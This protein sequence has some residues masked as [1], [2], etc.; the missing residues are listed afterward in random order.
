MEKDQKND[1]IAN[2][3]RKIAYLQM[4]LTLSDRMTYY[5]TFL[6]TLTIS[7]LVAGVFNQLN[8][9]D[10]LISIFMVIILTMVIMF[11]DAYYLQLC[12][13]Y[14]KLYN[15]V[16]KLNEHKISFNW[17]FERKYNFNTE[18][19]D[20]INIKPNYVSCFT[21]KSITSF[22]FPLL[23]VEI[24]LFLF[25]HFEKV[26][27]YISL[28]KNDS[29]LYT[30][31]AL[32]LL[33][34]FV[35]YCCIKRYNEVKE[36]LS[37]SKKKIFADD[38]NPKIKTNK[39]VVLLNKKIKDA[40]FKVTLKWDEI[41]QKKNIFN[42]LKT[43]KLNK[44]INIKYLYDHFVMKHIDCDLSV[45]LLNDKGKLLSDKLYESL[46][47]FDNRVYKNNSIYL[48]EDQ[49]MGEDSEENIF[50]Y[51]NDLP[52]NVS[53]I[54][55]AVNIYDANVK[56]QT[57]EMLSEASVI[58]TNEVNIEVCKINLKENEEINNYSGIIAAELTKY[59]TEWILNPLCK[60]IMASRLSSII[61][62]YE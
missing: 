33:L 3:K 53:K 16:R 20:F 52:K 39:N 7:I 30:V 12:K 46:I 21:S 19:Y 10:N 27:I 8:K 49:L 60:G 57:F 38:E 25:F 58:I 48:T 59:D 62:Y 32:T 35:L 37:V 13:W 34:L 23:F 44:M 42:D 56:N 6:K 14:R 40:N 28:H 5:T 36:E 11:F 61:K 4:L 15:M 31:I 1:I 55:F 24:V 54:V 50:V 22:Y 51:L 18:I 41:K 47:F 9:E 2:T 29:V 17:E 26:K 45:I 43:I